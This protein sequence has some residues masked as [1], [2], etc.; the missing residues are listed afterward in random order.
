LCGGEDAANA[1]KIQ[2]KAAK[3]QS[4]WENPERILSFSPALAGETACTG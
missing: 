4:H 3:A 1:E 2:R